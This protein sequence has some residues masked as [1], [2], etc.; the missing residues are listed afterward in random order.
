[1]TLLIVELTR[2]NV[3]WNGYQQIDLSFTII[4]FTHTKLMLPSLLGTACLTEY[5]HK[6]KRKGLQQ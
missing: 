4:I 6:R 3:K 1:M 5:D 2:K